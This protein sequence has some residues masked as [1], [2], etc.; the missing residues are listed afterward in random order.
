MA[1]GLSGL[2]VSIVML[3]ILIPIGAILV[4]RAREAAGSIPGVEVPPLLRAYAI[5]NGSSW[6][7]LIINFGSKAEDLSGVVLVSGDYRGLRLSIPPGGSAITMVD[8]EPLYIVVD[9][10]QGVIPVEVVG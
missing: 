7:L 4:E 1:R 3:S 5:P 9:A 10:S 2:V 8:G 6:G